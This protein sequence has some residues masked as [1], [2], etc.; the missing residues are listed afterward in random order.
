MTEKPLFFVF[1]S[2]LMATLM[3][4]ECVFKAEDYGN[5]FE[6]GMDWPVTRCIS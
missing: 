2:F 6:V 1:A 5:A 4:C 3:V